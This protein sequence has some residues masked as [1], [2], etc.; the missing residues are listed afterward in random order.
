MRRA[1]AFTLAALTIGLCT[2]PTAKAAG[3]SFE[4]L[5]NFWPA[6]GRYNQWA[7]VAARA[8]QKLSARVRGRNCLPSDSYSSGVDRFDMPDRRVQTGGSKRRS[9]G[10]RACAARGHATGK[11]RFPAPPRASPRLRRE[12]RARRGLPALRKAGRPL[13]PRRASAASASP[14]ARGAPRPRRFQP[15]TPSPGMHK[16][17]IPHGK[18]LPAGYYE[19]SDV[20]ISVP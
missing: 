8:R 11:T 20:P 3:A 7:R 13:R 17:L 16:P 12:R 1:P 6:G 5:G 15:P 19:I 4:V 2:L 14:A 18:Q 9:R 10:A